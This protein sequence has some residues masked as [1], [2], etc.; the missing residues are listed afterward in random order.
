MTVF[1]YDYKNSLQR[2]CDHVAIEQDL[3]VLLAVLYTVG[4]NQ[5]Y[6]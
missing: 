3:N 2:Q 1:Y 4:R 6:R 5:V